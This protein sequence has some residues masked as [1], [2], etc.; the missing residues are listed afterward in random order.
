M[1]TRHPSGDAPA[2]EAALV[3]VFSDGVSFKDWRDSGMIEREWALYREIAPKY[4]RLLIVTHGD[5]TDETIARELAPSP[6]IIRKPAGLDRDAWVASAAAS[7]ARAL[8]GCSS[9]IVKT[10][11]MDAGPWAIAARDALTAAG[12]RATL[13]ARGGYPYSW[14]VSRL[15]GPTSEPARYAAEVEGRLCR[16]ADI[17]LGT[18][19]TMLDDLCWRHVID[20]SRT[21]LVPNYVED[22]LFAE[23][24]ER[25][26]MTITFAGRLCDQKRVDLLIDAVAALP[27]DLRDEV[28]LEII[29]AG[30]LE[31]ALRDRAALARIRATFTPRIPH[32]ALM[33]RFCRCTIYAQTSAF[34]GHPKT[35][36]EAMACGAP[37]LVSRGP[38]ISDVVSDGV[39]G[40]VVEPSPHVIADKLAELL[41]DP[42]RRKRLGARA[43]AEARRRYSLSAVAP[44]ELR[45]HGL[46][47]RMNLARAPRDGSL[48]SD[49][50]AEAH[51][52]ST[53]RPS[54]PEQSAESASRMITHMVKSMPA[55]EGARFLMALDARLYEL[56]GENA[57]A[58][59]G[60]LHPK[61]RHLGY[62]DFFVERIK[63]GE[64]VIDLGSG[65]GALAESIA[66]RAGARVTGVELA[67]RNFTRARESA[68]R[69]GLSGSLKYVLGDITTHR[70]PGTFDVVVLSN[71]LEHMTDREALLRQFRAWYSPSRFLIRVPAFD[72]DWRV[73][74]KKELGVEWR[75]DPTHETEYTAG[76]LNREL[77]E[78][79]LRIAEHIAVWGEHWVVAEAA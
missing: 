59:D 50:Q 77:R 53:D 64:R 13:I 38:G 51:D 16:E 67:E 56:H 26:P 44:E 4:G 66:S 8:A 18:T 21:K 62:H 31:A 48:L 79:G 55:R 40:V 37:V 2:A 47:A 34:E 57:V 12:C 54:T 63:P 15:C 68:E 23:P 30:P 10:N 58:A 65:V 78:A 1:S 70:A 5:E 73:P 17:I 14:F 46:A 72:R 33:E 69:K 43:S 24:I 60:G 19:Q 29:G 20:P 75:L 41:R 36:I 76:Q 71:V 45:A 7:V 22:A 28:T 74:W 49:H 35:V 52:R 39:T 61:H 6:E 3:L 9:A 42:P 11:Q 25:E 27:G 32:A